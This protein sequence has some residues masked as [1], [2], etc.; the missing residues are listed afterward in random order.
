M[1]RGAE[2]KVQQQAQQQAQ[3]YN[4][5]I[6][7]QQAADQAARQQLTPLYLRLAQWDAPEVANALEQT[8]LEPVRSAFDA[9]R[10]SA[11][12]RV[13]RTGNPAG[14]AAEEENLAGQQ[15]AA[16]GREAR[17]ASLDYQNLAFQRQ[18]AGLGGLA[19]LYGIDVN[20]LGRMLG[21][22]IGALGVAE[23]A[24]AGQPSFWDTFGQT[25]ARGLGTALTAG[26]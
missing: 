6:A 4:Q 8:A 19:S 20:L 24:A 11:A 22:P 23:R 14:Y 2:K 17:Q 25:V 16:L 18:M 21:L 1:S 5:M 9:L 3:L 10:E 26:L 12:A 13:A 15:A 7:A